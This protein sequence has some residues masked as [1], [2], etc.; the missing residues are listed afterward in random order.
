MGRKP[1]TQRLTVEDCFA[2]D[3]A[4][5]K[6]I[7]REPSD[8]RIYHC[9]R[10]NGAG[11]GEFEYKVEI[12]G[13]NRSSLIL[14]Y[15]VSKNDILSQFPLQYIVK[16][17]SS[18]CRYGG[19]RYSFICPLVRNGVPCSK[20]VRKLLLPPGARYFGCRACYGL[21]YESSRSHNSHLDHLLRLPI[22]EFRQVLCDDAR[23]FGSLAFRLGRILQRRLAKKA[24]RCGKSRSDTTA[25]Y[26]PGEKFGLPS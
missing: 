7:I 3:V 8:W 9:H 26:S 6:G 21:C 10:P 11:T 25:V 23:K 15:S 17:S 20:R 19:R 18:P 24:R 4:M 12:D 5:L 2:V 22:Q 14:R 13:D 1:W 16:T